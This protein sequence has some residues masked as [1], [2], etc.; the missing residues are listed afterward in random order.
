[1]NYEDIKH[2]ASVTGT[3][4]KDLKVLAND[5]FYVRPTW[6]RDGEWFASI[7]NDIGAAK[8]VHLRRIHYAVVSQADPVKK[9]NGEVYQN[10]QNDWNF[11]VTA[12]LAARYLGLVPVE[13]LADNRNREPIIN[14][15]ETSAASPE[16]DV[17][18]SQPYIPIFDF[19]DLPELVLRDF[20]PE[21]DYLVEIWSEKSTLDDVLKPIARKM[22]CNLVVCTGETS[23][24]QCRKLIE[25]AQRASKPVRIV[26]LSDFDPAGRSM[27]VAA[28]RKIEY[29]LRQR[30]LDLDIRLDQVALTPE[31]VAEYDLPRS[32]IKES[33]RRRQAFENRFGLGATEIEA[34]EACKPGVLGRLVQDEVQRWIDPTLERRF[35]DREREINRVLSAKEQAIYSHFDDEIGELK[36]EH[37]ELVDRLRDFEERANAVWGRVNARIAAETETVDVDPPTPAPA[38]ERDDPLFDSKRGYLAQLDAY[39]AW[40]SHDQDDDGGAA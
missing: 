9:P 22:R 29:W 11:L 33:E 14:A 34:L 13:D 10:T 26:Y 36:A 23:E 21:Q 32:F 2:L 20:A 17:R 39:H 4:V 30:G 37:A 18:E 12:S 31:Q 15:P 38:E 5:P 19:P 1:M 16:V 28:A 8:G 35:A 27:P 7:W 25:R 40:Q 24:V 3:S 6:K